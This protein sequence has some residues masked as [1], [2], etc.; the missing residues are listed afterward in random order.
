VIR[1][2]H[3][4][5]ALLSE[6]A[7]RLGSE[8]EGELRVLHDSQ[9]RRIL[10]LRAGDREVLVKCFRAST[11]RHPWRERWKT[12]TGTGP[13]DREW[14]ALH[15]LRAAGLP[16]PA[17]L[18]LGTRP[19]GDR[20]L[21][22]EFVEGSALQRVLSRPDAAR[23][24]LC[25]ELG[26]LVRRIHAAGW[27][28]RDLHAGNLL[29]AEGR[30]VVLDWQHARPRRSEGERRRDL[31][32]LEYS[33]R[34]LVSLTQRLRLRRAALG[35]EGRLDAAARARLRAVG[36]A[37]EARAHSHATRRSRRPLRRSP[38]FE[39]VRA[40]GTR[41]MRV[42]E[43]P[44]A[45]VAALLAAHRLALEEAR[46]IKSDGRSRVSAVQVG[47]L[48]AVVKETPWRGLPRCLA[49][50]LRGSA[51]RRAWL[52][53]HGLLARGIGA[54]LP[55][56]Y[57][58]RRWL[59]L[60]LASWVML[61]DA[62]PATEAAFALGAGLGTPEEIL[63]SLGRLLLALHRRGVDHGDLKG[64]HVLLSRGPEGLR[65]KL[66]DLEGVRFWRRIPD[67]RRLQ[68]LA[69][70]NASLPDAYSAA[71]RRRI[72]DRYARQLPF[73]GGR[74]AALARVVAASL[75]RRHRWTGADCSL[76][77]EMGEERT[78]GG[79]ASVPLAADYSR[80]NPSQWK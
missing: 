46:A 65:A 14:D 6:V 5:G 28:H 40:G 17:P 3:G 22:M 10:R 73:A 49:A 66:I 69:E 75:A 8:R 21:V 18:A 45:R 57:L 33:L 15:R 37:V 53:G 78:A 35:I 13:A 4:E 30:I 12:W 80:S 71:V 63:E 25:R 44:P 64:T 58:E 11:G 76:A 20:L 50:L 43:L 38:N 32:R 62:R 72:F 24:P 2:S 74:E 52:A 48:R 42:R 51:G 67:D 59:G 29:L 56:A 7:A 31:A 39:R 27:V 55:L 60:P 19:D 54:A 16:V 41:G 34:A 70:L 47:A 36:Q 1:W 9:R 77:R 23:A 68:A 26:A 61:E 79:P